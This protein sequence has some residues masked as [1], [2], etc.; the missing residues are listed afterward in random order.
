MNITRVS[1][2]TGV[3]RTLDIPV[4]F[5]QLYN[6]SGGMLIQDAIPNISSDEREFIMTGITSD[7]W[8]DVMDL[9]DE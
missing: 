8:E 4:T 5:D 7:E 1:M 6:W 2:L 3:E 9:N